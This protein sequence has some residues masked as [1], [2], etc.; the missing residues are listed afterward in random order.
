MWKNVVMTTRYALTNVGSWI[1]GL[2]LLDEHAVDL[3]GQLGS[4]SS[5]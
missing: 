1:T 3:Q 2:E 5:R 4:S